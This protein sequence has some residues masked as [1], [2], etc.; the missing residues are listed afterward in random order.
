MGD[1]KDP[2]LILNGARKR[3]LD[4]PEKLALQQVGR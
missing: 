3:T 1:F 4:M 2:R